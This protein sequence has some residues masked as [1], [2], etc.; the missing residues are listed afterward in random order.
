MKALLFVVLLAFAV[1]QDDPVEL[2]V[3]EKCPDEVAACEKN[4]FCAI[5]ATNCSNKCSADYD[6]LVECANK[7]GNKLLIA[8]SKCGQANCYPSFQF[9]NECDVATCAAVLKEECLDS[10]SLSSFQCAFG[11]FE[12]HPECECVQELV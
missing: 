2:C 3:R 9:S 1:A 11:F 7:S 8:L 4:A 5:A 6:C 10:N 12:R